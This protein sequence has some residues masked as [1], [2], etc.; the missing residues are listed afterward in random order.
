MGMTTEILIKYPKINVS[1]FMI[2][3]ALSSVF[4]ITITSAGFARKTLLQFVSTGPRCN[5]NLPLTGVLLSQMTI[6]Q[7]CGFALVVAG[8][9]G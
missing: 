7:S 6:L 4:S 3:F 9:S 5:G 2:S 1:K 8:I